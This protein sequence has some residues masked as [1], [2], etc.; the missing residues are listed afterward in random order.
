MKYWQPNNK[1]R[2]RRYM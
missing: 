1:K 2:F